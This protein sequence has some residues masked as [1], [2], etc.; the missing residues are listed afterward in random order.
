MH[1]QLELNSAAQTCLQARELNPEIRGDQAAPGKHPGRQAAPVVGD[2]GA[3]WRMKALRRAQAQAAEEGSN[4]GEVSLLFGRSASLITCI[5]A[6]SSGPAEAFY[7]TRR[8][9]GFLS[10][11]K[12]LPCHGHNSPSDKLLPSAHCMLSAF[13]SQDDA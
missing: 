7:S 10:E 12:Q 5:A 2:G 11:F 9:C 8:G 3:S 4:L 13:P 1:E 6:G